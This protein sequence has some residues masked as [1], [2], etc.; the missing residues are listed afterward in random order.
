MR[1]IVQAL[2]A[3][4]AALPQQHLRKVCGIGVSGQMHGVMFWKTGQG[5]LMG[6]GWGWEGDHAL[7]TMTLDPEEG[8][9]GLSVEA[10]LILWPL[11]FCGHPVLFKD[12]NNK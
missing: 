12:V 4:L 7:L 9:G 6:S 10:Q 5:M 3:C 8:C 1:R 2:H 11:V